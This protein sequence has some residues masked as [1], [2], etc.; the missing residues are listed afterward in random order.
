MGT[1]TVRAKLAAQHQ[2]VLGHFN[3]EA[4][5][6]RSNF[7]LRP[8]QHDDGPPCPGCGAVL[9]VTRIEPSDKPDCDLLTFECAWCEHKQFV[10]AKRSGDGSR[11]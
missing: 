2:K 5:M 4:I 9:C 10:S 1:A 11:T 7:A 3:A 6:A 8:P